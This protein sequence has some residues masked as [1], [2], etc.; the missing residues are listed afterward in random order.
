MRFFANV[1]P[2]VGPV[3]HDDTPGIIDVFEA[4]D[5]LMPVGRAVR[6]GQDPEGVAVWRLTVYGDDVPGQWVI[7]AHEFS[8][9]DRGPGRPTRPDA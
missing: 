7:I 9:A 1:G 5:D 3:R 8:P 6:A 4:L 2:L